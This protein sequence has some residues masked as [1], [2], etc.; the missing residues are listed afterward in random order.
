MGTDGKEP[1]AR[2]SDVDGARSDDAGPEA[3][4]EKPAVGPDGDEPA[5][6][7]PFAEPAAADGSDEVD[8][9]VDAAA[10]VPVSAGAAASRRPVMVLAGV[11]VVLLVAS[12][13]LGVLFARERS[14]HDASDRDL[15]AE[16]ARA[17]RVENDL[18]AVRT[19]R[20][21]LEAKLA[22]AEAQKLSPE[23][24]TAITNCVKAYAEMERIMESVQ[25]TGRGGGSFEFIVPAEG[26]YSN[27]LCGAAEPH[28]PKTG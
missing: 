24:K 26:D 18:A 6:E 17:A 16:T 1:E 9:T 15:R 8:A 13:V 25:Q 21:D 7:T 3:G 28:L 22:A 20:A 27:K 12:I 23:A 2:E 5:G 10:A 4:A 19:Q 14:A 11:S